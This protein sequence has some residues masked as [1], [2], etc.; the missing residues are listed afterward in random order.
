MGVR[1]YRGQIVCDKRW[2]DG[3]RTTRVCGNKTQAKQLLDRINVSIA[4]GSW[5]EFK[6]KLQLRDRESVTL[7][8]FSRIYMKDFVEVRNKKKTYNRKQTSLKVLNQFMGKLK[9]DAITP[10]QLHKF[11]RYHVLLDRRLRPRPEDRTARL[12]RDR[13]DR[14]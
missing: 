14:R 4:D 5:S 10:I 8:E 12:R 6:Q 7:N 1:K 3:S 2:P 11:V 9:L 13:E